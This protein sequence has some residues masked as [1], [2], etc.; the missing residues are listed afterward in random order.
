VAAARR[1]A[2]E[3]SVIRRAGVVAAIEVT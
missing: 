1:F 2:G 3:H